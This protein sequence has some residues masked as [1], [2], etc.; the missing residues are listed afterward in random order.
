MFKNPWSR[1]AWSTAGPGVCLDAR[2]GV[3]VGG[4]GGWGVGDGVMVGKARPE[5]AHKHQRYEFLRVGQPVH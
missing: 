1:Q 2:A 5:Q 4:W 3:R